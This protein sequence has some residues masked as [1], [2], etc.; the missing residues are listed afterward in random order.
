MRF[1]QETTVFREFGP[2]SGNTVQVGYTYAPTIGT[3]LLGR[4]TFDA[5]GRYYYRIGETGLLALRARWFKSFGDFPDFYYFGGNGEMRGYEYLE[6]IGHNAGHFNAELRFPLIE[7]MLTPIGVLG[8]I[9]GTFFFNLGG[10]GLNGQPFKLFSN[11][12]EE[13]T[14]I[15]GFR[16]DPL[17]LNVEAVQGS[18]TAV[19]G[20]RLVNGRASY[21]LGLETFVI[22]FPVHFDW[23]WRTLFNKDW[24]DLVY[25]TQGGSANFRRPRFDFWIG[26]DF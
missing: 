12:D 1:V 6:F 25:A 15:I 14:P 26:Y 21:G 23:S 10:A 8:G 3:R 16:Q 13:F 9:R 7:A 19:S 20:F 22:G 2:V 11:T 4:Q 24:E 17:T 18:T 5:D